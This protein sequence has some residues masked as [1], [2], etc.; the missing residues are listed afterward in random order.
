MVPEV[1]CYSNTYPNI[2]VTVGLGRRR[3]QRDV[4]HVE[5]TEHCCWLEDGASAARMEEM[6]LRAKNDLLAE[7]SVRKFRP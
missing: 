6:S 5:T 3:S 7:K 4:R 2:G 1:G